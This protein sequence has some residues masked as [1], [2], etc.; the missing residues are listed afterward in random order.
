MPIYLVQNAKFVVIYVLNPV[1]LTYNLYLQLLQHRPLQLLLI[2]P[3]IHIFLYLETLNNL[4][5]K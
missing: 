3:A 2:H 1:F 5:F 4:N